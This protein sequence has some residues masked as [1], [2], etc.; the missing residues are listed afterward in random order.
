MKKLD[1]LKDSY[2]RVIDEKVTNSSNDGINKRYIVGLANLFIVL[3]NLIFY[4][5]FFKIDGFH[6]SNNVKT[7]PE[8]SHFPPPL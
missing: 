6:T 7:P 2:L 1:F 8:G 4:S 3:V 5:S